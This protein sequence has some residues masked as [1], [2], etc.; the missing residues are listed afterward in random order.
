[1]Q[2]SPSSLSWASYLRWMVATLATVIVVVGAFN[3]FVDPLSVFASPRI[4]QVNAIKPYLDHH[5]ELTRHQGASRLCLDTGIFGNSRAEIGFDP[6][7]PAFAAHALSAF[8]HAIPGTSASTPL[9]Q[10]AWLE[11]ANCFPKTII[12]GVEFFDFLG[13]AEPRPLPTLVTHPPPQRDARF[14]AESVFSITGLRD[15]LSTVVLQ[16]ARY[17]ASLTDRGFNPLF[18]YIPEVEQS[19]HYVLFRQRA[20][21]NLRHWAGK[22]LRLKPQQERFSDD[23]ALV[24]AIVK[25][26]AQQGSTTYLV[27]Y[28]YHAEICLMIERLGMGQ[29]FAD[30]KRLVVD[31]AARASRK[32]SKVEVW[33][34]SALGA[35]TLETIPMKGD[36]KTHLQNYWE[37]GHFKRELGDRII[38]RLLGKQDNFGVK[39]DSSNIAHWVN[40]DRLRVHTLLKTP[41]PLV[42]EVDDLFAHQKRR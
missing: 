35:E 34:F 31:I 39:L 22:P 6:N 40:E 20:E 11:N 16:R 24:E 29:L 3:I 15:S 30:W 38:D 1:M 25:K 36:R 33:D 14:F 41:S 32:D 12:L 37:A 5:R 19:G 42:R 28:P 27:I 7:S 2:K 17:P 9:Q 13:G 4:A 21:E 18:N 26:A 10:M 8:N 23:E